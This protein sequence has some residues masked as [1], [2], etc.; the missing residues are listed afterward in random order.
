MQIGS[1]I[2][3]DK[4][5]WQVLD[6]QES[7]ALI[8]TEDII[9]QRSYH[10][11]SSEVTWAECEL[12][13]YLNTTFYKTFTEENRLRIIPIKHNTSGNPWYNS[14]GSDTIEDYIFLL[15]I[16]E[17]VCQY[18]GDSRKNLENRSPKQRYWFQRKDINNDKRKALYDDYVWWWWLR[19]AGRDNHRA[20][21]VHGDGN[22]GIQGNKSF[23]YSSSTLH[24]LTADN[25]GGIRPATWIQIN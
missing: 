1:K 24:P 14:R 4:Y 19:S 9:E 23:K 20:A 16:E 25:N 5:S 15:S 17:V 8:I 7:K 22:I 12:R 2:L 21:Y 13:N 18:F 6:I 11:N 3:F 10:N